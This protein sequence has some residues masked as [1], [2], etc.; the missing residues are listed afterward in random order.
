MLSCQTERSFMNRVN[1]LSE[2]VNWEGC[3]RKG[4]ATAGGGKAFHRWALPGAPPSESSG[5]ISRERAA[6]G[7]F[8]RAA[9]SG[10]KRPGATPVRCPDLA[11]I[12]E[13]AFAENGRDS[14]LRCP[15][16]RGAGGTKCARVHAP[17]HSLRRLALRSVTGTAQRA[18]PAPFR[19][20]DLERPTKP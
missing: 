5:Q 7:R 11:R 19:C 20:P 18:I 14:A 1:P 8:A 10:S 4:P 12:P 17:P 9:A 3:C 13:R 15:R 6:R 2:D 16:P